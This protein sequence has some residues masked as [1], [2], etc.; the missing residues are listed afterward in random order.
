MVGLDLE[1]ETKRLSALRVSKRRLRLPY[2]AAFAASFVLP[3]A[4]PR[5]WLGNVA[6]PGA[7][8]ATYAPTTAS[9][10]CRVFSGKCQIAVRTFCRTASI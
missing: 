2:T 1:D 5:I 9:Y 10:S 4:W 6:A 7:G 8:H 3:V